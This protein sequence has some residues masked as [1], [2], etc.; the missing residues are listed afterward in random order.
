MKPNP[1]LDKIPVSLIYESRE[2]E[3]H[4][5]NDQPNEDVVHPPGVIAAP[6][7]PQPGENGKAFVPKNITDEIK[8]IIG[9]GWKKNAYNQYV[10]DLIGLHRSL[11]DNRDP[12]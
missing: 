11:P 5:V 12:W 3:H 7:E 1:E 10:S 4:K 8:K 9:E 6:A 2:N